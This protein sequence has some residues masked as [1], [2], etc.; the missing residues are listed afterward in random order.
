MLV[1]V[2]AQGMDGQLLR[3]IDLAGNVVRETSAPRVSEQLLDLGQ[4]PIGAFHHEVLRLPNGHTAVIGSVERI[5]EDVQGPG[6]VDVLGDMIVV[7]DEDWQ[8]VWAWNTF[9]HLDVSRKATL[10]TRCSETHCPPL[11]LAEDA[12]D[13]THANAI[14]YSPSDGDLLFSM[15]HQDWV[16]KIDYR[17]GA[18]TG[19]IVWKLGPEG[20]FAIESDDPYPWFTHQH[21][22][23]YIADG[24]IIVYDNGNL[25]CEMSPDPETCHSRGQVYEIDDATMTAS[26]VSNVDLG[27]YAGALGSAQKLR[28]GNLHFTSGFQSPDTGPFGTSDEFG[29]DDTLAFSLRTDAAVYRSFRVQ[30]LYSGVSTSEFATDKP[31]RLLLPL[32]RVSET[33]SGLSSGRR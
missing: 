10:D 6:P 4:D 2:W 8:V 19:D 13:W 16:I 20:D 24:Q 12:N 7:L 25:R 14:A 26:L 18:G 21:D 29:A 22:A 30:N 28:N 3:E 5:L 11:F 31:V 15:R 33:S 32:I 1:F 9:D 23:H 27:N 17:D